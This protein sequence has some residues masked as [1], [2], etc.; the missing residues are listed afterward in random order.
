MK[1]QFGEKGEVPWDV[2]LEAVQNEQKQQESEQLQN[3]KSLC[4]RYDCFHV[5]LVLYIPF[6]IWII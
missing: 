1:I 6:Y 5:L 4:S 3:H 2:L